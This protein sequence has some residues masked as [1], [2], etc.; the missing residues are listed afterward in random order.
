MSTDCPCLVGTQIIRIRVP[1]A[2]LPWLSGNKL[3]T[4]RVP[5]GACI[6]AVRN[7]SARY[8]VI[9]DVALGEGLPG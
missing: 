5:T 1:G 4:G 2:E 9:T 8:P 7:P 6:R 3:V